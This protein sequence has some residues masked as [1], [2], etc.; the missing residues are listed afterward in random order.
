MS[1][2][3]DDWEDYDGLG[4]EDADGLPPQAGDDEV[5]V[6][7]D[8]LCGR[9]LANSTGLS[10]FDTFVKLALDW[11]EDEETTENLRAASEQ[12]ERDLLSHWSLQ[13]PDWLD[14]ELADLKQAFEKE[15]GEKVLYIL[16]HIQ[17]KL[18]AT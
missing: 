13:V 9:L 2:E 15:D 5:E 11:L 10:F 1:D 8:E 3:D 16:L 4:D 18:R 17:K 7:L 12:L 6:D 14:D